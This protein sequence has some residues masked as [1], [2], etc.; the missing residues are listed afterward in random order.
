MIPDDEV[1]FF[2]RV[3]D[4]IK[5]LPGEDV[6]GAQLHVCAYQP[7]PGVANHTGNCVKC[8]CPI[9]FSD[10]HREAL[11]KICTDCVRA[12]IGNRPAEFIASENSL[13]RANDAIKKNP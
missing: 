12:L 4:E 5:I 8:G 2:R 7:T 3:L 1:K 10:P 6:G 9:Y 13:R 11:P